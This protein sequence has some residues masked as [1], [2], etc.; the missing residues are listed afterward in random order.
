MAQSNFE[1][2]ID[3]YEMQYIGNIVACGQF[4]DEIDTQKLI[5]EM[6]LSEELYPI[7]GHVFMYISN[8]EFLISTFIKSNYKYYKTRIEITW[9]AA[10]H[11]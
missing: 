4:S 11:T 9:N 3:T 1:E 2:R 10:M 6:E 5:S 7:L 8:I